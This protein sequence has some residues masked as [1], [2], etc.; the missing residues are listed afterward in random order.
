MNYLVLE[1]EN[2]IEIAHH[3]VGHEAKDAHLCGTAIVQLNGSLL[4]LGGI[5]KFVPAKVKGAIAEVTWEFSFAG[6]ITVRHLHSR[7]GKEHLCPDHP[8]DG[9]KGS[10]SSGDVLCSRESNAG[11]ENEEWGK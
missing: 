5:V 8:R 6:E 10:K 3:L 2:R 7:P 9:G 11:L 4:P 1:G